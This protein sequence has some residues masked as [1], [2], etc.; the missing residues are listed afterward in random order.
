MVL[1]VKDYW[2]EGSVLWNNLG[3]PEK[4]KLTVNTTTFKKLLRKY[5]AECVD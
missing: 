2:S 4:L 3:L 1:L 5:I